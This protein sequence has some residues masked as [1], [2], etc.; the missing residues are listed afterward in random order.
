VSVRINEVTNDP[1]T[2]GTPPASAI[3]FAADDGTRVVYGHVQDVQVAEGDSVAAGELVARIG[4]NGMCRNPH[5]HV[6]AWR[7]DV[8]LQI[9][10]DLSAM[11]RLRHDE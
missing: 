4:N 10:F 3:I 6:G 5:V 1:G 8:P 11:G 7:D 9:R 2:M